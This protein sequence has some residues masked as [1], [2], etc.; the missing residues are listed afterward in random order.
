MFRYKSGSLEPLV[1]NGILARRYLFSFEK[2]RLDSLGKGGEALGAP[3]KWLANPKT[4]K[5][6][7]GPVFE[8]F[9][10]SSS[11]QAIINEVNIAPDGELTIVAQLSTKQ[12]VHYV[13]PELRNS[14]SKNII[15]AFGECGYQI[16]YP[17][18]YVPSDPIQWL[19]GKEVIIK[20]FYDATRKGNH[21]LFL[22]KCCQ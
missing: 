3:S 12:I 7:L 5:F 14:D 4:E 2:E 6:K 9:D 11:E 17:Y 20:S 1:R 22:L 18:G 15:D 10:G 21:H 16:S 8:N 13:Y 19:T